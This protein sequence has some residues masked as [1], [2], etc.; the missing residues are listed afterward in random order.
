MAVILKLSGN[1]NSVFGKSEY[2]ISQYIVQRAE[3]F[4]G[5]SQI[6]NIFQMD[7]ATG[8]GEKFSYET[9]LGDFE[10]VGENGAVPENDFVEGYSKTLEYET[11]KD[12]FEVSREMIDDANMGKIKEKSGGMMLAH[13]RTREKFGA[14]M[15]SSGIS[16]TMTFGKGNKSFDI[17]GA[18]GLPLFSKSHPS[19]TGKT[20][21]QT[22]LYDGSYS[23]ENLSK[24]ETLMQNVTDDDGEIL[25]IM[26]DTIIIPNDATVKRQVFED[27]NADGAPNTANNNGN[28]VA[29]RFNIIV[30]P[31]LTTPTGVT[32]SQW[33]ILMDSEWNKTYQG[34]VW[35]DRVALEVMSVIDDK[36]DA[37]I[38]KGYTRFG[39]TPNNW[40]PF[41]LCAAGLSGTVL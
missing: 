33:F 41:A 23:Y 5:K 24:I 19:K 40:R 2:P 13:H 25:S 8:F 11:W 9:S 4:E 31:Y 36:T 10:P 17:A 30:W 29:G 37:N 15:L 39:A 28:F 12:S 34:L 26:P 1:M 7:K 14:K 38:W 3:A 20:G 6:D 18:D 16:T 35:R 22:N 21:L 27:L 32:N